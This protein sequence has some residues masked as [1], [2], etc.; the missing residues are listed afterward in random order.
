MVFGMNSIYLSFS[1]YLNSLPALIFVII[2]LLLVIAYFKLTEE[3]RLLR[4]FGEEYLE[5][6]RN[7]PMMSVSEPLCDFL[8]FLFTNLS[9]QCILKV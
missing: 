4:D 5:Y 3:K 9:A 2:F 6:K 1:I 7:V 8:D